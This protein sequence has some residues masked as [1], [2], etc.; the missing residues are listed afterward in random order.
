MPTLPA[1]GKPTQP[2]ES[3]PAPTRTQRRASARRSWRTT[4]SSRTPPRT[5][6]RLTSSGPTGAP[7]AGGAGSTTTSRPAERAESSSARGRAEAAPTSGTWTTPRP[8]D[9]RE[10]WR[11]EGRR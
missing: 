11:R 7:R 1:S 3:T 4:R 8:G 10:L 9:L 5:S 2:A 6:A